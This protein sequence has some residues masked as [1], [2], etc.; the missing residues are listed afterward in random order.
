MTTNTILIAANLI[1]FGINLI[2]LTM[3]TKLFKES[4]E[5]L[6]AGTSIVIGVAAPVRKVKRQVMDEVG[7]TGVEVLD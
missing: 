1:I 7:P 2:L 6:K 5:L 3:A 4:C